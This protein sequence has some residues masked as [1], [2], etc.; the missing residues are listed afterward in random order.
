MADA[1]ARRGA[2]MDSR[3]AVKLMLAEALEGAGQA[4]EAERAR[5]S[6]LAIRIEDDDHR[7][8]AVGQARRLADRILDERKSP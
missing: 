6:A 3:P 8:N 1:M 4:I 7:R 2:P 5:L